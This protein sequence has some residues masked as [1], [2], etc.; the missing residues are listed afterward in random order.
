VLDSPDALAYALAAFATARRQEM[1]LLRWGDIDWAA[2]VV[3]PGADS[4]G[5]KTTAALRG[6]PVVRTLRGRLRAES[7]RQGRPSEDALYTHA[8]PGD[9][10]RARDQL[11]DF[12]AAALA[13]AREAG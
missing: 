1:R 6:V 5:R 2:G 7:L 8:L 11:D 3:Y 13:E 12:I 9:V 4:D 10:E